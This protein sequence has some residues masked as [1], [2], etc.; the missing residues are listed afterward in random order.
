MKLGRLGPVQH[1]EEKTCRICAQADEQKRTLTRQRDEQ[2]R[3]VSGETN[4]GRAL[5]LELGAGVGVDFAVQA[6]F[7]KSGSSPFH[8]ESLQKSPRRFRLNVK[9]VYPRSGSKS[10]HLCSLAVPQPPI[11]KPFETFEIRVIANFCI[12]LSSGPLSG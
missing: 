1:R 6:N 12:R 8:D 3:V 10:T 2:R 11:V 7:F 9:Q 5:S 4:Q